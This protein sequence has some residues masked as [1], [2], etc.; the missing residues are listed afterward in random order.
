MKNEWKW[1]LSWHILLVDL[2]I[3]QWYRYQRTRLGPVHRGFRAISEVK[4]ES[5]ARSRGNDHHRGAAAQQG[6]QGCVTS[7][8]SPSPTKNSAAIPSASSALDQQDRKIAVAL[9]H[10][11]ARDASLKT[12]IPL[13]TL[14]RRRAV[15]LAVMDCSP[16]ELPRAIFGAIGIIGPY[17]I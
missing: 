1:N 11:S 16:N 9:A 4:D 6:E 13:W 15:V 2:L 3:R 14:H 5:F 17:S 10:Q 12:G 7:T 8:A